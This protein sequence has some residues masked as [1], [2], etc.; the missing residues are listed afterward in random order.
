MPN[1]IQLKKSMA[2]ASGKRTGI[3]ARKIP[4]GGL[5]MGVPIPPM[6]AAHATES[7]RQPVK[8]V[9]PV[10]IPEGTFLPF[11]TRE[12]PIAIAIGTIIMAVAVLEIHS[13]M[14]AVA[15]IKP[16]IRR[17]G[18]VPAIRII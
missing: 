11:R 14:N 18:E 6:L 4:F 1:I 5:P 10:V 8:A 13:E 2:G 9:S 12:S 16:R 15:A 17:R 3:W 7:S